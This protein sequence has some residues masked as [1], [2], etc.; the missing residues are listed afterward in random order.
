MSKFLRFP[1]MLLCALALT[2]GSAVA[3]DDYPSQPIRLIVGFPPGGIAD[4]V[5]RAVASEAST[6]LGQSVVVENRPGAGATIAANVGARAKPDGYTLLFLDYT[7]HAIND[8]LYSKLPYDTVNDFTPIAMV[9]STPLM[10]VVNSDTPVL[11]VKDL[12]A[13]IH[14]KPDEYFYGSSGNG[15]IIHLASEMMN[16]ATNSKI[17]HIPYNGSAALATSLITGDI[18]YAFSS[19][20]PAISQVQSG[21]LRALAVTTPNRVEVMPDVPT[22]REAGVPEA[23]VTMY[24]GVAGPANMPPEIVSRLNEVFGQ[25]IKSEKIVETFKSLGAEP[26]YMDTDEL[27]KLLQESIPRYAAVINEVGT[28]ID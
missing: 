18:E 22:I 26:I 13:R 3:Q 19:M 15:T 17:T 8:G 20:P 10:L 24:S 1:S 12:I 27:A 21:K 7:T 25:V 11:T 23:E 28:R 2:C 4:V 6:I 14:E 5:A 9:S 16:K